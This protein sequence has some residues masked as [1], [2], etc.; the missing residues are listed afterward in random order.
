MRRARAK[1]QGSTFPFLAG[2]LGAMGSLIFFLIVMDRRAKIVRAS[3]VRDALEAKRLEKS[4]AEGGVS[5]RL[6]ALER[7]RAERKRLRTEADKQLEDTDRTLDG[8]L[9]A[10][11][12]EAGR[13]VELL[14]DEE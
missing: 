12:G 7:E 13:A 4:H 2:L 1:L 8:E 9:V 11:E 5:A 6:A 10:I 3:K 14:K